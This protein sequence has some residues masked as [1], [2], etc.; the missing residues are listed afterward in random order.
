M[1][2]FFP[3]LGKEMFAFLPKEKVWG[4]FPS[5]CFFFGLLFNES[6]I[7]TSVISKT[8]LCAAALSVFKG[9]YTSAQGVAGTSS[10]AEGPFVPGSGWEQTFSITGAPLRLTSADIPGRTTVPSH[11]QDNKTKRV[12]CPQSTAAWCRGQHLHPGQQLCG[13]SLHPCEEAR[14]LPSVKMKTT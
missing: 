13:E 11:L 14:I 2:E 12:R 6:S 5:G 3:S 1:T 4:F 10:G 8:Y 9:L 7:W